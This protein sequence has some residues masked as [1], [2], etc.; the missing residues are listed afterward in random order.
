[1]V[2]LKNLLLLATTATAFVI[3]RDITTTLT[4]LARIDDSAF[5]LLKSTQKFNGD[6]IDAM[7]IA[8]ANHDIVIKMKVATAHATEFSPFTLSETHEIIQY[9]NLVLM[10]TFDD[11]AIMIRMKVGSL[12]VSGLRDSMIEQLEE[13]QTNMLRLGRTLAKK[14]PLEQTNRVL[15]ATKGVWQRVEEALDSFSGDLI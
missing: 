12:G 6:K 5:D 3:P 15:A 14:A 7:S 4:D 10:R 9:I 13:V 2:S 11:A 8:K 1:M